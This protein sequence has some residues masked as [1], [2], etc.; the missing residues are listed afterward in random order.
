MSKD[1]TLFLRW[2]FIRNCEKNFNFWLRISL[3]RW[4]KIAAFR[5]LYKKRSRTW[6]GA[7]H[8]ND[9][10]PRIWITFLRLFMGLKHQPVRCYKKRLAKENCYA[11]FFPAEWRRR[12][13]PF[14]STGKVLISDNFDF[15][16]DNFTA[17]RKY[18]GSVNPSSH[19]WY[20]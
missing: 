2:M 6:L 14:H 8:Y 10:I 5:N 13:Y 4:V 18:L 7:T 1:L 20:I 19:L 9:K 12:F 17:V 11:I 3:K 15:S 16:V